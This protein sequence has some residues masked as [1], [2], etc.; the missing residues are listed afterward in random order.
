[1]SNLSFKLPQNG[2]SYVQSKEQATFFPQG[3]DVYNPLAGQR[4]LRFSLASSG[5]IDLS[6]L[7]IS[8]DFLNGPT[9]PATTLVNGAH[10][11]FT[12]A[13]VIISGTEVENVEQHH[14]VAEMFHRLLPAEKKANVE[15]MGFA[16]GAIAANAV[17]TIIFRPSVLGICNQPLWIP[18]FLGSQGCVLELHL[19]NPDLFMAAG[20]NQSQTYSLSNV[21]AL[22]DVFTLDSGLSNTYASHVLA[23]KPLVFPLKNL[24]VTSFQLNAGTPSFDVNVSRAVSRL[25]SVFVT[26]HG[27]TGPQVQDVNTFISANPETIQGR[28]QI[29]SKQWPDGQNV[30]GVSQFWYRLLTGLGVFHSASHTLAITRAQYEADHFIWCSD[31]ETLPVASSTGYNCAKGEL[32]TVSMRNLGNTH[33]RATVVLHH[34]VIMEIR[35]T[36]CDVLV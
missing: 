15:L 6:S 31:T 23:G 2:A 36:G 26:L 21:R 32:I 27:A 3:G 1:M 12:R 9:N 22:C 34:D 10:C 7:V 16:G 19:T 25:N 13:R 20:L 8:M 17:K 29:G 35:D 30:T 14:I 33:Q 18:P 28:V 24:V 4:I 5:Y 11:L